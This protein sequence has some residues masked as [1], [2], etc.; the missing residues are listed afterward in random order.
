MKDESEEQF[1]ESIYTTSSSLRTAQ[2]FSAGVFEEETAFIHLADPELPGPEYDLPY[3]DLVKMRPT[4]DDQGFV[5]EKMYSIYKDKRYSVCGMDLLPW[6]GEDKG[7][8]KKV[9]AK[10]ERKEDNVYEMKQDL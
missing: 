6:N 4:N 5:W 10:E 7:E 2:G 1:P 8:E 3:T 9:N